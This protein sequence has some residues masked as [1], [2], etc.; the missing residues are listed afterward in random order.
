M[1]A[2]LRRKGVIINHKKVRKLMKMLNLKGIYPGANTS[3]RNH[4]DMAHPYLLKE[5]EINRFNIW[6]ALHIVLAGMLLNLN[7]LLE[8]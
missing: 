4:A 1:T 2:I 8:F 6:D 5:L 3:A 7:P